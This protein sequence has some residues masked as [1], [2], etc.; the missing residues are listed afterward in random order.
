MSYLD[1]LPIEILDIIYCKSKKINYINHWSLGRHYSQLYDC[2]R[3]HNKN[4]I[5]QYY[6]YDYLTRSWK[7][8]N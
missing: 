3:F 2:S 4:R 5:P 7:I 8:V 6:K 1:D